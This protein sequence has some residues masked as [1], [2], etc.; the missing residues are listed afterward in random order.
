MR[1]T[2]R[3]LTVLPRT[4]LSSAGQLQWATMEAA[5]RS[6]RRIDND[7]AK[8]IVDAMRASVGRRGAAASTF[9]H[10]AQEAGVSRGLLHYYFGTKERLLAEVVR[11]DSEIRLGILEER[12]TAAHSIDDIVDALVSQLKDFVREQPGSQSVIYEMLSASRR[13]GEIRGELAELYRK[14]R[15]RVG[16]LLRAKEAD[17]VVRLRGDA[18]AVASILFAL[19]DGL[20]LQL[21][22]D[23]ARDSSETFAAGIATA[24][25]LLGA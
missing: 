7:K 12:L 1:S 6:D 23:P 22:S 19:G 18:E 8:R 4:A 11:R 25:F 21:V 17:G 14:V 2:E 9:D 20:E 10:V 13:N 15:A 24:R 5:V 3:D 16:E